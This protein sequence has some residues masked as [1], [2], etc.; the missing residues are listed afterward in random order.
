MSMGFRVQRLRLV[1]L[2]MLSFW[3][4]CKRA[5]LELP[6]VSAQVLLPGVEALGF[7]WGRLESAGF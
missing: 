2:L 6:A 1:G 7:Y 5:G 4:F 3:G